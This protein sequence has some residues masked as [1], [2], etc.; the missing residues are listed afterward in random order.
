MPCLYISSII[1]CCLLRRDD[2]L[3]SSYTILLYFSTWTGIDSPDKVSFFCDDIV[4]LDLR[5][6]LLDAIDFINCSY[7]CM[8]F[9]LVKL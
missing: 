3:S 8:L 1:S 5:D 4:F 7:A 9:L 6:F 2:G